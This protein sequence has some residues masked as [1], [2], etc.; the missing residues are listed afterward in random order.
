LYLGLQVLFWVDWLRFVSDVKILA[1]K[2]R[3]VKG[4]ENGNRM[5]TFQ[6]F[7]QQRQ[8]RSR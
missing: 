6:K 8:K 7:I 2:K 5:T 1:H 4:L 3:D